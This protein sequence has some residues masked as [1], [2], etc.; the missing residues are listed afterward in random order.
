[1]NLGRTVNN[2][3]MCNS[4]DLYEFRRG[5][6]YKDLKEMDTKKH[7]LNWAREKDLENE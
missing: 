7:I 1:M 6:I 5:F 4:K 3:R 2:C